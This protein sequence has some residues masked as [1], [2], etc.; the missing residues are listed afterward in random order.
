[1][2]DR[3]SFRLPSE[4]QAYN[5]CYDLGSCEHPWRGPP[6]GWVIPPTLGTSLR[7]VVSHPWER[8]SLSIDGSGEEDGR[9]TG[10]AQLLPDWCWVNS[11]S[12]DGCL[13]PP[14]LWWCEGRN[15]ISVLPFWVCGEKGSTGCWNEVLNHLNLGKFCSFQASLSFLCREGMT[16]A[17]PQLLPPSEMGH[18]AFRPGWLA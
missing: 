11:A 18:S 9:H 15:N 13:T 14:C 3:N 17:V 16:L 7:K 10:A 2:Q 6:W 12:A 1:M 8:P 5:L 4:K